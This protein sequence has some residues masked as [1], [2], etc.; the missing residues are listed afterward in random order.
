MDL[1]K[2]AFFR[3]VAKELSF[4]KAAEKV[5][6]TQPAVSQAIKTLE[7]DLGQTLFLRLGRSIRLTAAGQILLEHVEEAFETLDLAQTRME[8]LKELHEGELTI[9]ASDTTS[10][11]ILPDVLLLYRKAY[12]N[13]EVKILNRPS[14]AAGLQV[15]ARE[16]DLG[17][18]TLPVDHPKLT[19]EELIIREDVAI[20]SPNHPLS[21]KKKAA[22][23]SLLAYPLI[24]LDRGSNTRSF[25]DEKITESGITP[26]ISMKMGSIE[27]IKKMVAL[28]FGI[29]IVPLVSIQQELADG[30]LKAVKV[31]SKSQSRRLGLIYP[32]KGLYSIP[33][34]LFADMIRKHLKDA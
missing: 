22:F 10:C 14:P 3:M 23:K 7:D 4:S 15:V 21:K 27:V 25:I 30:Q 11:Y 31:F 20:C 13:I 17:I 19:S 12:P 5:F 24:L 26:D 33:A 28:D 34:R 2:L 29:S 16:S 1:E 8:G 18:V 6:R 32:A 9:S